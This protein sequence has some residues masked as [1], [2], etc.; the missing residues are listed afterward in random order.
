LSHLIFELVVRTRRIGERDELVRLVVHSL[1]KTHVTK[2]HHRKEYASEPT[3]Y[4]YGQNP[5]HCSAS[6]G[7]RGQKTPFIIKMLS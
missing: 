3:N 1:L 6:G 7:G 2:T 5:S 4:R